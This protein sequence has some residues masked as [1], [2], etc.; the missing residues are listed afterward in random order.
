MLLSLV[1]LVA[2]VSLARAQEPEN[3]SL[4]LVGQDLGVVRVDHRNMRLFVV[5]PDDVLGSRREASAYLK[6]VAALIAIELPDWNA[7]WNVSFFSSADVAGYKTEFM[8]AGDDREA[9]AR[10]YLAEFTT[11]TRRLTYSPLD[12]DKMKHDVI[13]LK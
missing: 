13:E 9:W 8:E 12:P 1:S 7:G 3:I 4:T 10:A 11:K 6:Q 2:G 5:P